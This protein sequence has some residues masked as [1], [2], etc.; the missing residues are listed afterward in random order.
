LDERDCPYPLVRSAS[1]TVLRAADASM[2]K[3]GTTT[4]EAAV[5][6]TLKAGV[7]TPD[8]IAS[9]AGATT[10]EFMAVLLDALPGARRDTEF[11]GAFA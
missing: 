3:S 2:C 6:E 5:A 8:L 1:F 11:A 7:R 10:R 4:L 9:G